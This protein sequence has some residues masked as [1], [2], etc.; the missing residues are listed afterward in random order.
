MALQ[1][2][3]KKVY[4]EIV[5]SEK[6]YEEL[7]KMSSR[8]K[9]NSKIAPNEATIESYFD[10][11]LFAFFKENFESLGFEYKPIK[12]KAIATR[13]HVSKGRADTAIGALVVEFKQP[14]TFSNE[15]NKNKAIEQISEYLLSLK[16]EN[17]INNLG[18]VTDGING[19]FVKQ[20]GKKI[21]VEK[22]MEIDFYMLDRL[23][24]SIVSLELLALNSKNLVET[25]CNYPSNNGLAFE[26]SNVL[27]NQLQSN[28]SDKTIMLYSE[29]K[30]LF[31]LSHDDV[32]KQQAIIDRKKSLEEL[33]KTKFTNNDDEYK[34]LYAI[35]TSYAIIVKAIA[36][37][38][39]SKIRYKSEL[40]HFEELIDAKSSTLRTQMASLEEGAIFKDYNITNLLEGDFFSWYCD[41][42]QWSEELSNT[43]NRVF[44]LLTLYSDK[45]VTS[46]TKYSQD[47]F[48]SLYENMLPSAV[49]RSLGE[50]Y[51]KK[52]I[53]KNV[54]EN[55]ISITNSHEWKG[56]DPCCGSGT[57]VAVMIEKV[58]EENEGKN[59]K[60]ILRN[61]LE[62][63]KG[64]D[65]NPVTVLTA[66]VNYFINICDYLDDNTELE[67]PIYLG[68]SSYV[69]NTITI[70]DV[71]CIEYTVNTL[72]KPI[73]ICIPKSMLNDINT[74]SNTMSEI[75][76]F[77]H[78]SDISSTYNKLISLCTENYL[79]NKIKS[80][81]FSLASQLVDLEKNNWDGIWARIIKNFLITSTF[82]DFDIIVGNP[83]WVDW[84]SLPSGYRDKIK[85]LC[86]SRKLFSGDRLTGGINLNIC[87]LI[88]NVVCDNWLSKNGVLAFLM[89]DTIL[90][91]PSYEGFRNF[92]LSDDSR[93]YLRKVTN[94]TKS[95]NPFKP[96]TQKF[97]TYYYSRKY[98]DY[99]KGVPVEWYIKKKNKNIDDIEELKIDDYYDLNNNKIATC[100][101]D[102]NI[103]SYINSKYNSNDFAEIAGSCEYIGHEGIEFYPQE[104]MLFELSNLPNKPGLTSLSNFQ[105]PKSKYRIPKR[106]VLLE[107]KFLHPMIKGIDIHKFYLDK[108]R[109]IVAFPY[110]K[111]N[112]RVP[113][114]INK[115]SSEDYAPKLAKYYLDNKDVINSQTN[116][117]EKIIG[118]EADF[119]ALARVGAYSFANCYVAFRDNSK[120]G[121]AVVEDIKTDWGG[122]K[123]PLFQ[124]HAVSICE[125]SNGNFITIDEAHYICAILNTPIA[126]EYILNSSDSRSFPIRPRVYIPKYNPNNKIHK[127][128]SDLSKEAHNKHDDSEFM[129]II[130][131]KLDELYKHLVEQRG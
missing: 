108:P 83:P 111:E 98:I 24:Q 117:N 73:E 18:F 102:K 105:N 121:A 130:D 116:Y 56:I 126:S 82:K 21:I 7:D 88:A 99:N 52:W 55:A 31:N 9:N 112:P 23:I 10:C 71:E 11:E 75:E 35:Q 3:N 80:N 69:P 61:I 95:G 19:V 59:N 34:A 122:I 94:W 70:D 17:N 13:R 125:D 90:F 22:C 58:I 97:L 119:Y 74:F 77:I 84:K 57:F 1:N 46:S 87:A 118:R 33:L 2:F 131:E 123:R 14:S 100:H 5:N 93:L 96:V 128:L 120:W 66:R 115:L 30:E 107:T 76:L 28:M 32:S 53:A 43:L 42:N 127:E 51:T 64:V 47:F 109:F 65:L 110:E 41:S 40:I 15:K 26:L 81:V 114:A 16:Q 54:I 29:W 89:P 72:F 78:N 60:S 113:I 48:K 92:Y 106:N 4:L 39:L 68:D 86:I 50:Y 103:F 62:R 6:Y 101:Q 44:K 67:I 63:V 49:R 104:L 27:Y 38:V 37:K 45:P 12:E 79:T 124:N 91:Q 129:K 25:F 36:Y 85:S 20:D 8:I